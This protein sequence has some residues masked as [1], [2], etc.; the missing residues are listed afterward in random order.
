M[1]INW[2]YALASIKI[3]I[4]CDKEVMQCWSTVDVMWNRVIMVMDWS[5]KGHDANE[6]EVVDDMINEAWKY[7]ACQARYDFYAGKCYN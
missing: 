3:K 4:G 2:C 5:A 1:V 7:I 6:Y